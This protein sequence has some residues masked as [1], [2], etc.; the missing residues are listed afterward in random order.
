M[1]TGRKDY[2]LQALIT[3]S[4]YDIDVDVPPNQYIHG[5]IEGTD[6]WRSLICNAEGKLIIDPTEILEDNPTNNEVGKAPTSNWAY[7]HK[8]LPGAHHDKFTAADARAAINNLISASGLLNSSLQFYYHGAHNV[9]FIDLQFS[10]ASDY[11]NRIYVLEDE[12]DIKIYCKVPGGAFQDFDILMYLTDHNVKVLHEDNLLSLFSTLK[13]TQY[14]SCAGV[15]FDAFNP[16]IN[17]VTKSAYGYIRADAD[18]ISFVGSV[19]LPHGCT[20]T[21]CIVYGNDAATA[22]S[23]YLNR[24]TLLD[25][26]Y[27]IMAQQSINTEDITITNPVINNSLYVYYLETTSFD[28]DDLIY[29]ALIVYTL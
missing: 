16:A 17:L 13:G 19:N 1:A 18:G 10:E 25:G 11:E 26:T 9:K 3:Q 22:E 8:A 2:W 27:S 12:K 4:T 21:S 20:V 5:Q 6:D 15:H 24:V 28:T 14:W 23:W 29:G 7:D